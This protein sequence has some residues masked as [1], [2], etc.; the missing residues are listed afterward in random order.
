ML[1]RRLLSA[2]VILGILFTLM[3]L[4]VQIGRIW[5]LS[6]TIFC[7]IITL[8]ACM[9]G[10]EVRW[11]WSRREDCPVAWVVLTGMILTLGFSCAPVLWTEYPQV[12]HVGKIGWTLFG[13]A[14]AVG[15]AFLD[16]M[17][18]FDKHDESI[19][20]SGRLSKTIMIFAY[21]GLLLSF[22]SALRYYGDN[23]LGMLAFVSVPAVVKLSD[24][25]AYFT[26]KLIGRTR[27]TPNL[28][29]TKTL[30]GYGGGVIGGLVGSWTVFYVVA[31]YLFGLETGFS[32]VAV[33][34]FG[35]AVTV[36]GILG[37]LAESLLKR[38]SRT[39]D[40]SSWLPGLGGVLDII[41]SVLVAAPV[42]FAFWAADVLV[43]AE[44]A[45]PQ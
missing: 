36:A 19:V 3:W 23:L 41:D 18:R 9:A 13:L 4:D 25:A 43:V 6:G 31:P 5:G 42:G 8:V 21:V 30:E 24:A 22:L 7:V 27:I 45:S 37:D 12:C 38:E 39:K 20:V 11:M 34:L 2:A 16:E 40:S 35:L 33:T 15:V 29:P 44:V 14:A 10:E 32:W 1:G 28:S 26:G 17:Y